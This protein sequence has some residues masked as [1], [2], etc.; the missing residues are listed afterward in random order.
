MFNTVVPETG[1]KR[2]DA[3]LLK[4]WSGTGSGF[5]PTHFGSDLTQSYVLG[6]LSALR[7]VLVGSGKVSG[8]AGGC[9]T[10]PP[11]NYGPNTNYAAL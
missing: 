4:A 9:V 1:G 3:K 7:P 5:R 6:P 2:N 8:V 11:G 10:P